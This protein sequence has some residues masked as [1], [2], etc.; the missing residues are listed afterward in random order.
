METWLLRDGKMHRPTGR[1]ALSVGDFMQQQA[2]GVDYAVY[3]W[4]KATY[5][6][7]TGGVSPWQKVRLSSLA[8]SASNEHEMS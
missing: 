7:S 1:E 5:S 3:R 8:S 4:N 6:D 2:Q